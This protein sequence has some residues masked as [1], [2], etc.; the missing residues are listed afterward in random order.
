MESIPKVE[1]ILVFQVESIPK[2]ESILAFCCFLLSPIC[3]FPAISMVPN[4][5]LGLK[6]YEKDAHTLVQVEMQKF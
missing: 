5:V 4:N 1:S 3:T 2:V 6:T